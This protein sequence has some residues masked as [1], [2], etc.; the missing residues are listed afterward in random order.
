M[1]TLSLSKQSTHDEEKKRQRNLSI[2]FVGNSIQY[3]NDCPR[4]VQSMLIDSG[5]DVQQDSC[6][7]GGATISSLWEKGNGMLKK[8]STPPGARPQG[9]YDIG[10]PTPTALLE[11]PKKMANNFILLQDHTQHPTRP[12]TRQE[13]LNTIQSH[14]LPLLLQQQSHAPTTV[15]LLQTFAYRVP[16]L[17]ESE[18]LGDFHAFTERLV[19]GYDVYANALR[20][21]G[22]R[23]VQIV[24]MGRAVRWLYAHRRND[25]WEALYSWDDF[26]PSPH[27]TWLQACLI[28]VAITGEDPPLYNAL[29]WDNC[30]YMQPPDESPLPLPTAQEAEDLRQVAI[31]IS[32]S[33]GVKAVTP[34]LEGSDVCTGADEEKINSSL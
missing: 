26:H 16:G 11:P 14:F 18:D 21:G 34:A 12:S 1:A 15:L 29:W 23:R 27:G 31:G 5:Y 22:V 8:F 7:R 24:P 3:F 20:Q 33:E 6:L 19:E 13:S 9:G 10:A 17:K 30:R 2:S 25:L 4:L 32:Y 28:Y